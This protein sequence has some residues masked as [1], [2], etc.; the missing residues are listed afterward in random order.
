MLAGPTAPGH[1]RPIGM[2]GGEFVE[3]VS[4]RKLMLEPRSSARLY[5]FFSIW[6]GTWISPFSALTW[7]L[8]LGPRK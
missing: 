8:P 5:F 4:E 7:T 6:L 1:V 2:R 3:H